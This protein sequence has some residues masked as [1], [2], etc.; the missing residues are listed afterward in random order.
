MRRAS[1]RPQLKLDVSWKSIMREITIIWILVL[2]AC[3]SH[4]QNI[5]NDLADLTLGPKEAY[6][7]FD[8][9]GSDLN[10]IGDSLI[11]FDTQILF[12]E[13]S[14]IKII[15]RKYSF[16]PVDLDVVNLSPDSLVLTYLGSRDFPRKEL[17]RG[18][19]DRGVFQFNIFT[20]SGFID[21]RVGKKTKRKIILN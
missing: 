13:V 7:Y 4:M 3:S 20:P 10:I 12:G 18:T 1:L 5:R 15:R 17:F 21:V 11:V 2:C 19:L 14:N 8:V 6:E 16:S 9:R